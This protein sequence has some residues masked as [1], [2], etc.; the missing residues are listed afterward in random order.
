MVRTEVVVGIWLGVT[1]LRYKNYSNTYGRACM[2]RTSQ[3][4]CKCINSIG[5]LASFQE[6]D[7]IN[8]N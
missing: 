1:P 3:I 8:A 2:I 6:H 4:T 7:A 5:S